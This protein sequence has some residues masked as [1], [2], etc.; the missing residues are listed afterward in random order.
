MTLTICAIAAF[1]VGI[2]VG[3]CLGAMLG[4]AAA[5]HRAEQ[6]ADAPR[7][8]TVVPAPRGGA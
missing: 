8:L 6:L 7:R 5:R 1:P 2:A 3:L 4:M